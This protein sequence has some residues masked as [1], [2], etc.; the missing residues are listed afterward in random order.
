V[1]PFYAYD[2]ADSSLRTSL[3]ATLSAN[4]DGAGRLRSAPTASVVAALHSVS[5]NVTTPV[6]LTTAQRAAKKVGAGVIVTGEI[7]RRGSGVRLSLALHDDH[8]VAIGEHVVVDTDS[9]RV[10][11][12]IDDVTGQLVAQR[13]RLANEHLTRAALRSTRSVE[14]VKSYLAGELALRDGRYVDAVD[15]FEHATAADSQFALAYYRLAVAADWSGRAWLSRRGTQLAV[16]YSD[17][18]DDRDR[19]LVIGYAAF[20]DGHG[21]VAEHTYRSIIDDYPDDSEAW[22][23]LGEVLFHTN[24][25]RGESATAA[26]PA[27]ERLLTLDPDNLEAIIHLARIAS[28]QARQIDADALEHRALKLANA[29]RALEQRAFRA[30][31]LADRP[32]VRRVSRDLERAAPAKFG[33]A[34]LLGIAVDADD[35]FGTERFARALVDE[36]I[37]PSSRAFG[38]RLLAHTSIAQGRWVDARAQL[39]TAMTLDRDLAIGQLSL[40]ATMPFVP[41]ERLE[42]ERIRD[43]VRDWR[44]TPD[45][46]SGDESMRDGMC[47]LLR[48]HRLGLLSVRLGDFESARRAAAMLEMYVSPA[49]TRRYAYT[50]AQSI[51][52][53]VSAEQ[54]HLTEALAALDAADWEGPA[55]LFAAEAADRFFRASL[56]ESLGRTAEAVKWYSSIAERAAYELPYLAPAQLRLAG[57]AQ[58]TGDARAARA[59]TERVEQL[60]GRADAAFRAGFR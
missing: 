49:R 51:R 31:A 15:E 44:P 6:S 21:A 3:A 2:P 25:L 18:L 29:P 35:V 5:S 30:Y 11:Q 22:F 34:T 48:L 14:A 42:L 10:L 27:F 32:G 55:M 23:Q 37:S 47:D 28:L 45:S 56:L 54:G 13:Y 38:L 4:L 20:G 16:R 7:V 41:I 17:H 8:G 60:W 1:L 57:M 33:D 50:L 58:A 46:T 24:P 59:A 12:A 9:D 39:D 19:R 43:M 36:S 26:R 40:V 52:S 53:H